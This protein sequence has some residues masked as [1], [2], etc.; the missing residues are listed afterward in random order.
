MPQCFLLRL[1][2]TA[3]ALGFCS[4]CN[5]YLSVVCGAGLARQLFH[6]VLKLEIVSGVLLRLECHMGGL[7]LILQ[8]CKNNMTNFSEFG[9]TMDALGVLSPPF[10]VCWGSSL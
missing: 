5:G 7:G 1:G 3:D 4:F 9:H 10:R 6:V 2:S 8:L